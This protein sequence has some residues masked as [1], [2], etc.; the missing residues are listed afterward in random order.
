MSE[1]SV[2]ESAERVATEATAAAQPIGVWIDGLREVQ[3]QEGEKRLDQLEGNEN[4]KKRNDVLHELTLLHLGGLSEEEVKHASEILQRGFI[5]QIEAEEN[6]KVKAFIEALSKKNTEE[7]NFLCTP[8]EVRKP[9]LEIILLE[10]ALE[11]TTDLRSRHIIFQEL[12]PRLIKQ[13]APIPMKKVAL[14]KMVENAQNLQ[15]EELTMFIQSVL[16]EKKA[17]G[18]THPLLEAYHLDEKYQLINS[19]QDPLAREFAFAKGLLFVE[20]ITEGS[21]LGLTEEQTLTFREKMAEAAAL[22]KEPLLPYQDKVDMEKLD[23]HY[24]QGMLVLLTLHHTGELYDKECLPAEKYFSN[25]A[26][27]SEE[28]SNIAKGL[29]AA[30]RVIANEKPEEGEKIL[31][32][33]KT[34]FVDKYIRPGWFFNVQY[35]ALCRALALLELLKVAQEYDYSCAS[36]FSDEV[37]SLR[38]YLDKASLDLIRTLTFRG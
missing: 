38:F 27:N 4:S 11:N 34:D 5:Q 31:Q 1:I 9:L 20:K 36:T 10:K 3:I 2:N 7:I 18:F 28:F 26:R 22:Y 16:Q 24:V 35:D 25:Q 29:A 30:A 33:I 23:A 37:N 32:R 13:N 12:C 19:S 8:H 14:Y 21:S 6:P 17:A 15:A